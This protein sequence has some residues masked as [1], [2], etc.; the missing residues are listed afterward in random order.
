M[1]VKGY[2]GIMDLDLTKSYSPEDFQSEITGKVKC[3]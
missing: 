2:K 3:K 1:I